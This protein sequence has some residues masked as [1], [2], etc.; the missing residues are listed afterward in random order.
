MV[1][2]LCPYRHLVPVVRLDVVVFAVA[3]AAQRRVRP[4]A[5]AALVV[6]DVRLVLHAPD[7]QSAA[8]VVRCRRLVE[9]AQQ[10]EVEAVPQAAVVP[11]LAVVPPPAAV[12]LFVPVAR[13]VPDVRLAP[14]TSVP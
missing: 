9:V 6:P 8:G 7:V 13:L 10:L 2:C 3:A 12:P 14:G 4:A 5:V 1:S 11:L